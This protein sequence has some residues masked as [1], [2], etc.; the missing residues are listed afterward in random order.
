MRAVRVVVVIVVP[1]FTQSEDG[2]DE[3]VLA[4]LTRFIAAAA[5]Q[6]AEGIDGNHSWPPFKAAQP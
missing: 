3:T 4:R 5:Q 2:Q 1:A 6:M